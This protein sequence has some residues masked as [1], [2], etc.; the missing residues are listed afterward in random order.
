LVA[1]A[2]SAAEL[3][4]AH[5][6][7]RNDSLR[8]RARAAAEHAARAGVTGYLAPS[9]SQMTLAGALGQPAPAP[10]PELVLQGAVQLALLDG[11]RTIE[12][13]IIRAGE[14]R[15]EP[16]EQLA[17]ALTVLSPDGTH[18]SIGSPGA[19]GAVSPVEAGDVKTTEGLVS[20]F[21][22]SAKKYAILAD[23]AGVFTA[24]IDGAIPKL[25]QLPDF[26]ERA[27]AG[28]AFRADGVDYEKLFGE[29]RAAGL[30]DGRLVLEGSKAGFDAIVTGAEGSDQEVAAVL[31]PTGSGGGLI[32]RA[33]PGEASYEGVGVLLE[34][35]ASRARLLR[36]DGHAKAVQLAEPMPLPSMPA[37]GYLVS[38]K[39]EGDTA[40]ARIDG[41]VLSGKLVGD[42]AP[43]KA[44]LA[45][46]SEGRLD[47]THLVAKTREVA[48]RT[49]SKAKTRA[50][51]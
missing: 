22:L 25:T 38:L 12:V 47:V 33:R 45:V 35:D 3:A 7:A 14:G 24:R 28:E 26:R 34:A 13:A 44:G 29:P 32:V 19:G 39:V 36:F 30:D 2:E 31:R 8:E 37:R 48:A 49:A 51:K 15:P 9:P 11:Q 42:V 43:G 41:R 20:G 16:L 23:R 46:R 18:L 17:L 40:T 10:T 5:A 6:F 50:H 4:T 27:V 1:V 21:T